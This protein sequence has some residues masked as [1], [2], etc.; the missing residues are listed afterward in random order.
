MSDTRTPAI[1]DVYAGD[2]AAAKHEAPG[3]VFAYD[4]RADVEPDVLARVAGICNL[5]NVSPLRVNYERNAG[6]VHMRV[7]LD[8]ISAATADS[9]RRKLLQLTCVSAVVLVNPAA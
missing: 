5:A 1:A 7:E 2:T 9:I 3:A 4:I 8:G 6:D